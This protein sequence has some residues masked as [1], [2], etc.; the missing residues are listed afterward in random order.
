MATGS[1]L[2]G[3]SLPPAAIS[4]CNNIPDAHHNAHNPLFSF[5]I[6][7]VASVEITVWVR[8]RGVPCSVCVAAHD[9]IAKAR[10]KIMHHSISR[11]SHPIEKKSHITMRVHIQIM[12]ML[13]L[14]TYT[15]NPNIWDP[16]ISIQEL[17]DTKKGKKKK[18]KKNT[19]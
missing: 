14:H 18:E 3:R 13:T 11:Q 1:L 15:V 5:P 12:C 7:S 8:L 6:K 2:S 17:M 4:P 10:K 9:P 16:G 19:P